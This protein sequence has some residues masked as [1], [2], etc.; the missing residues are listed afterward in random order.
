MDSMEITY[1]DNSGFAVKI[2]NTALLFD[3]YRDENHC[4]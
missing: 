2:G 1:L 4:L 3:Y